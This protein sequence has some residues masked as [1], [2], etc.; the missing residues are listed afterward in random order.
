MPESFLPN[1]KP[2]CSDASSNPF[3]SETDFDVTVDTAT[4]FL[5]TSVESQ[6][7]YKMPD[8]IEELDSDFGKTAAQEALIDDSF[9]GFE[10]VNECLTGAACSSLHAP[11]PFAVQG[12]AAFETA[13][14]AFKL[15]SGFKIAGEW[16]DV[17]SCIS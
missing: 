1:V 16:L 4:H 11:C 2:Y 10:V 17:P 14:A 9:D 6:P 3:P 13:A 15:T 8:Q 7:P 5:E 12:T